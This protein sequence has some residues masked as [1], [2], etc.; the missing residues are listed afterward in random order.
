MKQYISDNVWVWAGTAL[1]L[2]TLS[3]TTL[4]T[5]LWVSGLT[6]CVHAMATFLR[7]GD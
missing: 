3:G 2:L 4:H 6:I 7:N 1:V 5:A